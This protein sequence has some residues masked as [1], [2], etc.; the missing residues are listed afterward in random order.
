MNSCSDLPL[1]YGVRMS[2]TGHA[3]SPAG[4]YKSAPSFTPSRSGIRSS[5]LTRLISR[6][7]LKFCSTSVVL[8]PSLEGVSV[9]VHDAIWRE[10]V[11][12]DAGHERLEHHHLAGRLAGDDAQLRRAE[13]VGPPGADDGARRR[14]SAG[15]Q[16][17]QHR[18][19]AC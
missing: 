6:A 16:N 15:E 1:S 12:G 17:L 14:W 8:R 5:S 4:R 18:A 2:S 11:E 3:A 9:P 10:S 13:R 19:D 7:E